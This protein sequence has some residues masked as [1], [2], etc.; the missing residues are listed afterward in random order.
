MEE[1]L[2]AMVEMELNKDNDGKEENVYE[3]CVSIVC[4]PILIEIK[5]HAAGW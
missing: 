5:V 4:P 3:V 1:Q 2:L